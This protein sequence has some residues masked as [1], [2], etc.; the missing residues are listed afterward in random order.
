MIGIDFNIGK[1]WSV[2]ALYI[3]LYLITVGGRW[4]SQNGSGDLDIPASRSTDMI[5]KYGGLNL[6]YKF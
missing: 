2:Q 5:W 3:P 4:N 6:G 1:R